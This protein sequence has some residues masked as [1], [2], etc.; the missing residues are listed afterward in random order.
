[1]WE[2]GGQDRGSQSGS[3][4]LSLQVLPRDI[5]L[6]GAVTTVLWRRGGQTGRSARRSQIAGP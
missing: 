2:V 3:G 1:M 5:Y 6:G 4:S